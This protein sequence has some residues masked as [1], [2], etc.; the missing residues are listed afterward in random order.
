MFRDS[1]GEITVEIGPK[2]WRGV[3][4]GV[5]DRIEISGE[6]KI[7]RGQVSI[8]AKAI[9][10]HGETITGRY[11]ALVNGARSFPHDAW[12]I[13]TGNIISSLP[14]DKDYMFRDQSGEITVEIGRKEWRGLTI[15]VSD[16]VEISGEV[17]I[18]K[19]YVSIKVHAIRI[20]GE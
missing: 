8:K 17:K 2:E 16:R 7:Q 9:A 19:G 4:V 1:T 15:G 6:V 14:G 20:I 5:S 18:K 12:V 3:T 10:G 13:L 11:P